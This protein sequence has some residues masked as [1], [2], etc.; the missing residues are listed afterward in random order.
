M[1][2]RIVLADR[3]DMFREVLRSLLEAEPDFTVIGDTGDG[4]RL[5]Q[6]VAKLKPDVLLLDLRLHKRS[7][8]D[9]LREMSACQSRTRCIV[10][11]DA[12]E[13]GEIVQVLVWGAYGL[14]RKE[15][16]THLLFKSIRSVMAGEYWISHDGVVELVRNVR[17]LAALVERSTQLQAHSLSPQQLQI[18]KAIVAG[19]SNREIAEDLSVSERTVKYHLTRIF[20]KLG[21]SGRM[22]LARYSLKNKVVLEA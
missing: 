17:S 20:H 2:T 6:L 9:V 21:V 12:I 22:Q 1:E 11:T 15:A 13:L 3:Q 4:E 18:V 16:S 10:L 14:V 5:L 8:I 19:C 7:G